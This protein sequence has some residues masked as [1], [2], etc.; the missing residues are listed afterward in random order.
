MTARVRTCVLIA[1]SVA[2][3]SLLAGCSGGKTAAIT[4]PWPVASVEPTVSKPAEVVRWPL[5]GLPAKNPTDIT[6]RPISVK[7]EN[8]PEARPQFGLNSA[9]VVYESVTE[10]GITRFNCI[11]QSTLPASVGPVRSARLS[12]LWVVPQYQAILFFSGASTSVNAAVVAAKLPN[13]SQDVGVTV[14]YSRVS[15]RVA[16]HNLF[17]DTAKAY[18]DSLKRGIPTTLAIKGLSYTFSSLASTPTATSVYVPFSTVNRVTWTYDAPSK[19]YLRVNDG[20]VHLDAATGKQVAARNV[21]VLWAVHT[22]AVPDANGAPTY[23]ITL[24]GTGRVSVFR[25]GQRFDGTW[26]A[27]KNS[28]PTFKNADGVPI[29]LAPGNTWFQVISMDTPITVK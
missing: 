22:P 1:A 18:S 16:P 21:V 3:L 14:P 10:G 12:D 15:T 29:K 23:D 24:G 17:L 28:P 9:D 7:I 20:K 13:M 8:S 26:T 6:R 4:S 19:T 11:F 2:A 25:D 5:T 27:E